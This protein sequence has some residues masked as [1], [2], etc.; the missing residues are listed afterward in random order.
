MVINDRTILLIRFIA[1]SFKF[2]VDWN[3]DEQLITITRA[4]N[5]E[6]NEKAAPSNKQNNV[7]YALKTNE[8]TV[9]CDYDSLESKEC[10]ENGHNYTE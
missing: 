6:A 8:R 9:I 2:D 7:E 3:G 4:A 1:E 10:K 5:V